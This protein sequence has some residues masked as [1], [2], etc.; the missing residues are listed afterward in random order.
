MTMTPQR[1]A[2]IS[3][4]WILP[5]GDIAP[6]LALRTEVFGREFG[7]VNELDDLDPGAHTLL[8][9]QDGQPVACGRVATLPDGRTKFGKIV[10]RKTLRGQ[11]IG[12]LVMEH[13]EAK[14]VELGRREVFLSAQL[15][16]LNFYLHLGYLPQGEEFLVQGKPHQDVGKK[17]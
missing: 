6:A 2:P 4:H 15:V 13:L 3:S 8:L 1:P 5:G 7:Y 14:A 12:R 17:L 11:Q 16:A 10:V 9:M